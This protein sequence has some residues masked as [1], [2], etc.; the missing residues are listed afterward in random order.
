MRREETEKKK[1]DGDEI[2]HVLSDTEVEN[3]HIKEYLD[4]SEGGN[5]I[6][7]YVE[8]DAFHLDII[9]I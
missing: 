5:Y 3:L 6:Q 1:N 9:E 8:P 2:V 7:I 4:C